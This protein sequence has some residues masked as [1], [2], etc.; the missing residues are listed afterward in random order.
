MV[1][2]QPADR[3]LAGLLLGLHAAAQPGRVGRGP[4]EDQRRP[5]S[6]AAAPRRSATHSQEVALAAGRLRP[7]TSAALG[8]DRRPRTGC[9]PDPPR[10]RRTSTRRRSIWWSPPRRSS[11]S[12]TTPATTGCAAGSAASTRPVCALTVPRKIDDWREAMT[13]VF[14]ELARILRPGGHV[15]FEVGE[16]RGG[17]VRL[18]EHVI[19]CGVH[20]GLDP[21][22]RADQ[23]AGVHED[24]RVLGRRQ[25]PQGHEHEPIVLFRKP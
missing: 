5:E 15:A 21:L 4:A 1:A 17:R 18:E 12:S 25:Q 7:G 19:P 13:A 2:R 6:G 20:A 22:L 10:P 14:S 9:L 23:R 3:P 11:T 24:R 8:D 16:V